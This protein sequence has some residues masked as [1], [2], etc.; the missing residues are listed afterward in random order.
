MTRTFN[1]FIDG[2]QCESAT[3]ERF[4]CLA[5][6][7]QTVWAT[8]PSAND[9]DVD[10]AVRSANTAFEESWWRHDNRKRA[11]VLEDFADKLAAAGDRL[12]EIEMRDCGKAIR[13]AKGVAMVIPS[14]FRYAAG[15]AMTADIG[16]IQQGMVPQLTSQTMRQP[17]G[18][19][20]VQVPWNNPLGVFVQ[21]ASLALAAGN[22]V[23]VKPSEFAPCSVLALAE[24]IADSDIPPGI[25]NIVSGMGP[26]TGAALCEH[27][28]IRKIIFTGGGTAAKIIARGA[29]ERMV[30]MVLELG[31][32]SPQLVFDD[33]NLDKAAQGITAG[34]TGG[35]G[36]SC[37]AGSRTFVQASVYEEF[38]EKLV[39]AVTSLQLGDPSDPSTDV[40]PLNSPEHRDR[41]A[42]MVQAGVD[43][44]GVVLCG[45]G[46]PAPPSPVAGH[47][48]F[49]EPTVFGDVDPSMKIVREEV[50]G[51]V[52]CVMRFE[53]EKEAVALA[54]DTSFGL[55]AGVWSENINRVQRMTRELYAGT[56]WVNS[57]RVGD[58]GFSFGGVKE[59]GYG[60]ECGLAGYH[61]MTYV[62]SVRTAFEL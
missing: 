21:E 3:G 29:A 8:A 22:A 45:G 39:T 12:S 23:V 60:R 58:P 48:L 7:E 46:S 18:V 11:M 31:G 55:A 51:P 9:V 59:S 19:M 40:G 17:Y 57:Y 35:T 6:Y 2:Q 56:V 25:I 41:V 5:P 61:E 34:F 62:K 10:R 43:E 1:M 20:A 50:F 27:P 36:Q 32:K 30:P 26:V 28:L 16:T 37:I 44:G 49:F 4:D 24:V 53:S 54:N 15:M 33:A 14:F 13:E 52:T 38:V 47:P 42:A